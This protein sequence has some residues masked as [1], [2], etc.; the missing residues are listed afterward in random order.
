MGYVI[1]Y[2]GR[3][4]GG[5]YKTYY[6]I[7]RDEV[8]VGKGVGVGELGKNTVRGKFSSVCVCVYTKVCGASSW[9]T[10]NE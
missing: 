5:L 1:R 7:F 4:L 10:W 3:A 8:K 9:R 2:R 6:G